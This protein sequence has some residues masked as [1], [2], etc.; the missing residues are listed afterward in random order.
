MSFDIAAFEAK[1]KAVAAAL[2]AMGNLIQAAHV[3]APGAAGLTKASLVINTAV[4]AEPALAGTEQ[5][6]AAAVTGVV[7]AYRSAGTLPP[8]GAA[9]SGQ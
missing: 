6:L 9:A 8:S 4:A 2:P 1:L 7:E 5:I 3:I